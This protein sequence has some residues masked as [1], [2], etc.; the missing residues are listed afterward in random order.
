[1]PLFDLWPN[2]YATSYEFVPGPNCPTP[3]SP[4]HRDFRACHEPVGDFP[5][6]DLGFKWLGVRLFTA[7]GSGLAPIL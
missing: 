5:E 1:M 3:P 7:F 2:K 4:F 6:V